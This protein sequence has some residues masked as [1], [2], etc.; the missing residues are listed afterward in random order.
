MMTAPG[1]CNQSLFMELV[2]EEAQMNLG[3][4]IF[5]LGAP[6]Q[7]NPHSKNEEDHWM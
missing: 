6:G 7:K 2:E 1:V 5:F 4:L 3:P